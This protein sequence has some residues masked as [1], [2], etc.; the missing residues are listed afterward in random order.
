MIRCKVVIEFCIRH[1]LRPQ[2]G[3]VGDLIG[4]QFQNQPFQALNPVQDGIVIN[5]A[6][7]EIG[8]KELRADTE[9]E[10][11]NRTVADAELL[12]RG[13]AA[14]IRHRF[15]IDQDHGNG[16]QIGKSV[17]KG[18]VLRT[19]LRHGEFMA[20][21]AVIPSHGMIIHMPRSQIIQI[22]AVLRPLVEIVVIQSRPVELVADQ[23]DGFDLLQ[24]LLCQSP[25][26]TEFNGFLLDR[27][28][29]R[30]RFGWLRSRPCGEFRNENAAENQ[31]NGS[32]CSQENG[33]TIFLRGNGVADALGDPIRLPS[34]N[35]ND[36]SRIQGIADL[37]RHHGIIQPER[38]Y[39]LGPLTDEVQ[40][41][42]RLFGILIKRFRQDSKDGFVFADFSRRF[43]DPESFL[44]YG[45]KNRIQGASVGICTEY[46][47]GSLC[48]H[49][50]YLLKEAF[51]RSAGGIM[52]RG[53]P[54]RMLQIP[55]DRDEG[56]E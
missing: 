27:F 53:L 11:G 56:K 42:L 39:V 51:R 47:N 23:I 13:N 32:A 43:G 15:G 40:E 6:A 19:P 38:K 52:K 21:P 20:V 29:H 49:G 7:V 37:F 4:I 28:F 34:G 16:H 44:P 48:C 5:S 45:G 54:R 2:F 8:A 46:A 14:Q 9:G 36:I 41:R 22:A 17:E 3:K 1:I 33:E 10:I 35:G 26:K 50:V 18:K 25:G 55:S 31:E 24:I 30:L 12:K